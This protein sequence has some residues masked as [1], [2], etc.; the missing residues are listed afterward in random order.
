MACR[1]GEFF[2]E[3]D[4][5]GKISMRHWLSVLVAIA[6]M[7]GPAAARAQ[8]V[9]HFPSLDERGTMLDGYLYRPADAERHPAVVGLHGCNG[10]LSANGT[11]LPSQFAW[12][13]LLMSL[14]YA[15]LLVDS[16]GPRQ[17]GEMCSIG[18]FDLNLYRARPRDAYG[19]LAWLQAQDFVRPERVAALGWSQGG[20]VVL[21]SIGEPGS[22]GPGSPGQPDFRAAVAFYPAACRDDREPPGWTTKVPLLVLQ[23]EADVWTPAAPCK[24]FIDGAAARGAN[25]EIVMYPGAYHAFDAPNLSRRELPDYVTRAGVVPIVATDPVARAD[26]QRRVTD[27]FARYLRD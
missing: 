3:I 26:A 12:A 23:G 8:Q 5:G 17:H 15:T 18:G 21:R 19:A 13:Y 9:V 24:A 16:L 7:S 4:D 11:I 1:Q 25:A 6:C 22:A 10:M 20:G 27:F 2:V 14:G